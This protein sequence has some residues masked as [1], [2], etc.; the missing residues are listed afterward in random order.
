MTT[1]Q[2]ESKDF[3][4]PRFFK[5]QSSKF[6]GFSKRQNC[7]PPH[8][9][10][11]SQIKYYHFIMSLCEYLP[12]IGTVS[13]KFK[14]QD[15]DKVPTISGILFLEKS[16]QLSTEKHTYTVLLPISSSDKLQQAKITHLLAE[17]DIVS[18]KV[19]LNDPGSGASS[20]TALAL[21]KLQKWSV[22]DLTKTPKDENNVN[23]F[24]FVCAQCGTSI[25]DSGDSKFTDMPSEYWHELMEFW[26]CHKPHQKHHEK[27]EKNYGNIVPKTGHV[28]IGASYLFV[29]KDSGAC[30][31]CG[32]QLGE[33]SNDGAKLYKWNLELKYGDTVETFPPFAAVYYAILDKINSGAF[34]KFQVKSGGSSLSLWIFNVG[35]S[36]S[37][38]ECVLENALKILYDSK[39]IPDLE[40][41]EVPLEVFD[42]LKCAL[43][44]T[45]SKLPP[46]EQSTTIKGSDKSYSVAYLAPEMDIE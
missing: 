13:I 33:T 30:T 3:P 19:S 37:Y 36:V 14:L 28:Y 24:Q 20:F 25:I 35:L 41:L 16:F 29:N 21:S 2:F 27:H 43:Q 4:H 7:I 8:I 12:Q 26:H 46:G 22:K 11:P 34:R 15:D 1:K 39:E 18:L 6:I 17:K 40:V 5:N 42:S 44:Q 38:G 10:Q 23:R 9:S 45:T 31:G 32:K